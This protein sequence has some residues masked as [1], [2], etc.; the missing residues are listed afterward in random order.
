[1]RNN[2]II[3][4]LPIMPSPKP[5][6][7][8]VCGDAVFSSPTVAHGLVYVGSRDNKLYALDAFTGIER[9]SYATGNA[10]FSVNKNKKRVESQQ[11]KNQKS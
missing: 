2:P 9:W 1:M 7:T 4:N 11:N 3:L 6:W 8:Y 5:Y 10:I